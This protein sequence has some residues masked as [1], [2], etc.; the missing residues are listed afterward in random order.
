MGKEGSSAEGSR[1]LHFSTEEIVDRTGGKAMA[2]VFERDDNTDWTYQETDCRARNT[3]L[4]TH[5]RGIW[6][7]FC[8]QRI[9]RIDQDPDA[10]GWQVTY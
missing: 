3:S 1:L 4:A 6:N 5:L 8:I 10:Y 2:T 9:E 7:P